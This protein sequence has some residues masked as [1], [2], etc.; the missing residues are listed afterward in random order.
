MEVKRLLQK[1]VEETRRG[2]LETA[3]RDLD[4]KAGK[5]ESKRYELRIG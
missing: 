5:L 1:E 4:E 3:A 2:H